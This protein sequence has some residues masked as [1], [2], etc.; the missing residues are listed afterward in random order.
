MKRFENE[1]MSFDASSKRLQN[2]MREALADLGEKGWEIVTVTPRSV[3]AHDL[4]VFLK[5]EINES[6]QEEAA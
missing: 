4:L 2:K 6:G 3:G 5:R 1:V